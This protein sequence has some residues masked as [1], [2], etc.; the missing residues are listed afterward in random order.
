MMRNRLAAVAVVALAA[1]AVFGPI[2]AALESDGFTITDE[3]LHQK[4]DFGPIPG[5]NPGPTAVDMTLDDCK[6]LPSSNAVKIGWKL[7]SD[8]PTK[9][10]FSAEWPAPDANDLDLYFFDDEGN[11]L[12]DSAS[13]DPKESFNLGG[14]ENGTY[15][16]CVNNFSGANAGFTV[17]VEGNFLTLYEPRPEPPTPKPSATPKKTATPTTPEPTEPPPPTPSPEEIDTPG[18]NGPTQPKDLL[19]VAN[20]RQATPTKEGRSGLAIGLFALTGVI[21][22]TGVGLIVVRIRRDTTV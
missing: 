8:K 14:L 7:K 4:K 20:Q 19:A 2:A 9:A 3:K 15:W 1:V 16:L 12:A 17:D 11:L 5:Q 22:A 13:A 10:V 21:A 6:L 18:P